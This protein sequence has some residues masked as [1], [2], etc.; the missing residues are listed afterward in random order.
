MKAF[1]LPFLLLFSFLAQSGLAQFH[2]NSN[3]SKLPNNC[4]ELTQDA[5]DQKGTVWTLGTIDFNQPFDTIVW[6]MP[7][8]V[9][10][11]GEGMV[12]AFHTGIISLGS[13]DGHMAYEALP[14]I[15]GIEID[16]RQNPEH[17]DPA[18]DHIALTRNG[19][20]DHESS[21]N[22]VG[23]AALS[24]T[25]ENVEDGNFHSLRIRWRPP[26]SFSVYWDCN[27]LISYSGFIVEDVFG[28]NSTVRWGMTAGTS[29]TTQNRHVLCL[30]G[31]PL[32]ELIDQ[33][34][35]PGG[36]TQLSTSFEAEKYLWS[37]AD[38]LDRVD[39]RDPMAAPAVTTTYFL[40]A[41]DECGQ[42]F[43][44]TVTVFVEG[45]P[46]A[47]D[48]PIDTTI[49]AADNY[50]IDA[51]TPGANYLWSDGSIGS[52][53]EVTSS[54]TYTL[55]IQTATCE[56]LYSQQVN[57]GSPP[58]PNLPSDTILCTENNPALDATVPLGSYLWN[59][60]STSPSLP[61]SAPGTYSVT[62]SNECGNS[63]AS[64]QVQLQ[65]CDALYIPTAFSPNGDGIN[66]EFLL[67]S[68]LPLQI[69]HF[70]IFDRW[71]NQVY[72]RNGSFMLD[73]S[74]GWDGTFRGSPLPVGPYIYFFRLVKEDGTSEIRSGEINIIR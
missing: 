30:S 13:Y 18:Y 69:E 16:T 9:D 32:N 34:I 73:E 6:I 43:A 56:A 29:V 48:I 40:Q 63:S 46:L 17:G 72:S 64:T 14:S 58:S 24:P 47:L 42:H 68:P 70:Q 28:G 45:E 1:Y 66:D 31:Q 25:R 38:G 35:C 55:S 51:T 5:L 12:F 26:N 23:P 49:C 53:L 65:S 33:T 21:D 3:A 22:L 62:I 44:D 36:Q 74:Q 7:G 10:E 67:Q 50:I 8:E 57:F 61:I 11:G 4:F 60:G 27:L 71:G 54:G 52:Q 39:I 2:T 41:T 19:A 15:L 20:V 59:D 37:P